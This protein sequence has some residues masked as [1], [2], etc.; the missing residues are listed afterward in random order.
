MSKIQACLL[1]SQRK[2]KPFLKNTPS[3]SLEDITSQ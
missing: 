3:N 1:E 2:S